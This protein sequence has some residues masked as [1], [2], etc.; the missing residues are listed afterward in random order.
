MSTWTPFS[1]SGATPIPVCP[2]CGEQRSK[3]TNVRESARFPGAIR[4]RRECATCGQRFTT[5]GRE[6]LAP[7]LNSTRYNR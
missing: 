2:S 4:R 3:V 7:Q 5:L 6:C 1:S